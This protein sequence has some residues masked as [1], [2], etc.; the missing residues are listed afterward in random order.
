MTS[1]YIEVKRNSGVQPTQISL[2]SPRYTRSVSY[3]WAP[4]WTFLNTFVC[5]LFYKLYL[6]LQFTD[7]DLE[8]HYLFSLT[9]SPCNNVNKWYNN[10]LLS[11]LPPN[12]NSANVRV[13]T[14]NVTLQTSL[15]GRWM[16][17]E[18]VDTV[19]NVALSYFTT[20]FAGL[21]S[22]SVTN[23]EGN[24]VV[25]IQINI[26]ATGMISMIECK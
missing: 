9:R 15:T 4:I 17:P 3:S 1:G 26:S 11:L 8:H 12:T 19:S 13:L 18:G 6:H 21:Y 14:P 16:G 24:Q 5:I 2:I 20:N 22:F 23:W 10:S 7:I 25:A